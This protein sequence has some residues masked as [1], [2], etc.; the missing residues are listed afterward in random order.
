MLVDDLSSE[1]SRYQNYN[2][3]SAKANIKI[4]N[5]GNLG[6]GNPKRG[7]YYYSRYMLTTECDNTLA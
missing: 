5:K 3:L 1:N 4:E 7:D 6:V 2:F